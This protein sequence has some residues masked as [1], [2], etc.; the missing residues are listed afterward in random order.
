[1]KA[2]ALRPCT[3]RCGPLT[4]LTSCKFRDCRKTRV[5]CES[6]KCSACN[7]P[8]LLSSSTSSS[9]STFPTLHSNVRSQWSNQCIQNMSTTLKSRIVQPNFHC[10]HLPS[11][12][13]NLLFCRLVIPSLGR[14]HPQWIP[15]PKTELP[16]IR[17][18]RFLRYKG[19][20]CSA[21]HLAFGSL[22][23]FHLFHIFIIVLEANLRNRS[24]ATNPTA[25]SWSNGIVNL[26]PAHLSSVEP[27]IPWASG[28]SLFLEEKNVR[29]IKN[30][31]K[32][33]GVW[34]KGKPTKK[35][36]F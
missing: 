10:Q 14:P 15:S 8:V 27:Q 18:I 24:T 9:K 2:V 35:N 7:L 6:S 21:M 32:R 30:N 5:P 13:P 26:R 23:N 29:S 11:I 20:R 36:G 3:V 33:G 28:T 17:T 16:N 4:S 1:M 19:R 31:K 25:I 22:L 12:V 34:S